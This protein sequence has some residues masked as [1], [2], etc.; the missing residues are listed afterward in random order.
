[1]DRT[2]RQLGA[3][4][5]GGA[6]I[7][8]GGAA[9]AA[10]PGFISG[11]TGNDG[12]FN[13]TCS[14]TPCTVT[15]PLPAS[16][17]FNFSTITIPANTTV[18]FTKNAA[19]TPAILLATESVTINGTLS[20][21]G[22]TGGSL[23]RPGPGGPGGFDGGPGGDGVTATMAGA[24]LGPGGGLPGTNCVGS[25]G[26][27]ATAGMVG[28]IN[29]TTSPEAAPTYGSPALRPIIG[30]SGGSG[31][32]APSTPG[33]A[34]GAGGGGGGALVIASSGTLTLNST[35]QIVADGAVGSAGN[36]LNALGGGGG[37]GGAIRLVATTLVSNGYLYARGATAASQ[38][39]AGTGGLGRIRVEAINLTVGGTR[40][41]E[42][43]QGL[44]QS[45]FPAAGQPTLTITSVA[46][47]TAP[48]SP[49]G[50]FLTTPDILLPSGT[51]NPLAVVVS[52]VNVPLGTT[53]QV[54]A[55]PQSGP[56]ATAMSTGL[57]G[58]FANSTA[59][60]SL[61]GVLLT[62]INVL[63]AS[64]TFPLVAF[65]A[66]PGPLYAADEEVTHVRVAAALGGPS[67]VTYLTRTGRE[68]ALP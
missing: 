34:G 39:G 10:E 4:V 30:G 45:V 58:T 1:M 6:L 38:Y 19:N 23:G 61:N 57:A 3:I 7:V 68:V 24:G 49:N 26:S 17:I 63:T 42:A 14:P 5:L 48:A 21:T 50:S 29:C 64:A 44:P 53:I 18:V 46:G 16:G 28:S 27:Y 62:Q 2:L 67:T 41:P 36:G 8:A 56:K 13:P 9:L 37:S 31:G 33:A 12:A 65:S 40:N 25:G 51:T 54:T 11:S 35:G 43:T 32:S 52:A 59:T 66:G 60:A 22:G 47:V 20:V 55:T 15:V